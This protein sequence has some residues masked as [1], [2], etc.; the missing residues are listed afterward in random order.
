MKWNIP[1]TEENKTGCMWFPYRQVLLSLVRGTDHEAVYNA[2][3][4]GVPFL[5]P[6]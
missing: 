2:V 6:Y 5:L 3:F 1:A 4:L